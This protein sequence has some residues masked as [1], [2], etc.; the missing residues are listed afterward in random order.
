[1]AAAVEVATHLDLTDRSVRELQKRGV[2]PEAARGA[3]DLDACRIAYLRHLRERAAGRTGSGNDEKHSL[4]AERARLAAEQADAAAM[5]NA[6]SRGEMVPVS[7]VTRSVIGVIEL[8]RSRLV[9]V[10]AIVAKSDAKLRE[11][12]ATALT[13]AMEDLSATRVQV[14]AGEGEDGEEEVADADD[15]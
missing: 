7:A 11:R 3:L 10:P 4:V 12:I 1:M 5:K 15:D 13:D 14:V 8:T 9:K 6:M 2:L